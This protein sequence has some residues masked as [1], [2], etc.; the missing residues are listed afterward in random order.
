MF[1]LKGIQTILRPRCLTMDSFAKMFTLKG[2]QT[3]LRPKCLTMDSLY[4]FKYKLFRD[5]RHT[6]TFGILL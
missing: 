4:A 2:I 3:I 1:A 5:T 6:V